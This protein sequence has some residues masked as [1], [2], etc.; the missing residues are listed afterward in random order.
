MRRP[1]LAGAGV[2]RAMR[3]PAE[4]DV[5]TERALGCDAWAAVAVIAVVAAIGRVGRLLLLGLRIGGLAA[6][7]EIGRAHV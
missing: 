4:R 1:E 2:I 3:N 5:V 7:V 6:I